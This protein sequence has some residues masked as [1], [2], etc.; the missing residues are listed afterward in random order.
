V[1]PRVLKTMLALLKFSGFV[2][3]QRDE[4]DRRVTF[5]EPT[6]RMFRF[7]R[8]WLDYA[9]T[10]LDVLQ[11][12]MRRAELLRADPGFVERFLVL[13][14]R[15]HI[16]DGPV[17]SRAPKFVGFFGGREGASAV[18]LSLM[19]A[20]FDRVA[21]PSRAA[22]ARRFGLSKTQVTKIVA[23]GAAL[24]FFSIDAAVP[25]S[26]AELRDEY[27]RWISLEL[28]FY[29]RHMQPALAA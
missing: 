6:G 5:Y 20:E 4:R 3:V 25:S 14:G 22:M 12:Q 18:I 13:G 17:A 9:V 23:E 28:A 10:S 15:D 2:D 27:A 21:P 7:V 26:T 11:P 19:Q 24:G 1:S 29:A 16:D 8:Q